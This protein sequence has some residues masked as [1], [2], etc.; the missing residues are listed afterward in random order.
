MDKSI[1]KKKRK[2]SFPRGYFPPNLFEKVMEKYGLL[3]IHNELMNELMPEKH[4]R[5]KIRNGKWYRRLWRFITLKKRPMT[6]DEF[7]LEM[8]DTAKRIW[9]GSAGE[10]EK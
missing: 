4:K 1:V 5:I 8:K 10:N 2:S 7:S 6:Y 9:C 3:E